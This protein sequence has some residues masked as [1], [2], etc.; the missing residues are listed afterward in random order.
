MSEQYFL[1][2]VAFLLGYLARIVLSSPEA[3][4]LRWRIVAYLPRRCPVCGAWHQK[5]NMTV[6][7]HKVAGLTRICQECYDEQY[8]PFSK[9]GTP[10][11]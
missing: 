2:A 3:H 1:L 8:H 4:Q 9:E 6:A 11:V 7:K 10:H 5:R